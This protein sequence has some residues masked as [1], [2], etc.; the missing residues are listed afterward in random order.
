MHAPAP[1][2]LLLPLLQIRE[3]GQQLQVK[4]RV[5]IPPGIPHTHVET[6][7][8]DSSSHTS[9]MRRDVRP[10]RSFTRI[11]FTAAGEVVLV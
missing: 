10:G 4:A 5:R 7:P 8:K 6:Y 3:D 1:R 11:Y 2:L 9:F